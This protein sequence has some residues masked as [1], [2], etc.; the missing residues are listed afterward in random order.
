MRE[1]F[2][3]FCDLYE[4]VYQDENER[5]WDTTS[6]PNG[7]LDLASHY[8][9]FDEN[10]MDVMAV[11]IATGAANIPDDGYDPQIGNRR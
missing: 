2:L 3:D 5:V 10:G 11:K 1:A 8:K 6:E 7:D 4:A 9:Q